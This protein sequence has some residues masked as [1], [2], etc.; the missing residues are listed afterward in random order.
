MCIPV[1]SFCFLL[2]PPPFVHA[3]QSRNKSDSVAVVVVVALFVVAVQL[4]EAFVLAAGLGSVDSLQLLQV[5]L[6]GMF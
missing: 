2:L 3:Y 6:L 4:S 5:H 1:R